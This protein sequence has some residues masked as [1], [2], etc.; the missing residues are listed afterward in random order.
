MIM[1]TIPL[2]PKFGVIVDGINLDDVT[3]NNLYPEI[4]D[5]FE[6]HS[7]ILFKDQ[8][9]S[10]ETHIKF[11]S[12]FGPLENREAM[13]KNSY[14]KFELPK[15]SNEDADGT[16]FSEN[17]IRTLELKANMLWHTDSTFLPIPALANI[18]A[19]K[20]VPSS[21]GQ[22]E[23]AS[24][25]I[26]LNELPKNI[27][28]KIKNKKFFHSFVQS[29]KKIDEK[30][31]KSHKISRWKPQE[32]DSIIKNPVTG[33]ESIYIASHVYQIEGMSEKDSE[34]VIK[35]IICFA[36]QDKYVYSHDWEVG[37]V[38]IWDERSILHRGRP[39]P[40]TEPRTLAS[41]CVSLTEKDGVP[42]IPTLLNIKKAEVEY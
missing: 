13:A 32:W 33:A 37:D 25:R 14:V 22:T 21:G 8:E 39:W 9:F 5:L 36:T 19:A 2:H 1:K 11:A 31:A 6:K 42:N 41:I 24:T 12:L 35:D 23:L 40:Y 34:K 28:E 3:N 7:S 18:I 10:E 17:D 20:T 38:L 30:L 4:R 27:L 26:A 16:V 29:R 15:V